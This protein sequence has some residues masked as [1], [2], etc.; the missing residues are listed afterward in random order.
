MVEP[1][2]AMLLNYTIHTNHVIYKKGHSLKILLLINSSGK[3]DFQVNVQNNILKNVCPSKYKLKYV[4]A[5]V[6]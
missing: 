6:K 4:Y 3:T 1:P 2:L 5:T